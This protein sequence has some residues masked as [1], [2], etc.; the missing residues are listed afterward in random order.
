M[1]SIE[2]ICKNCSIKFNKNVYY[3]RQSL[4]RGYTN[5]FCSVK[6]SS[7]F[8]GVILKEKGK[9]LKINC[10]SSYLNNQ[11]KCPQCYKLISYKKRHNEYCSKKCSAIYTQKDKGHCK[12]SSED[13]E[14]I[15]LRV[16]D[17]HN[18]N[19]KIK[20][21]KIKKLKI[22]KNCN[23]EIKE[24]YKQ[25]CNCCSEKYYKFYRP[26]CEFNFILENYP[27]KF[28]LSLIKKY[29]KYSPKNKGNNLNG[30]SRDHLYSVKDGFK[31]KVSP[32]IIRHPS[33]CRLVKHKENQVK[34]NKSSISLDELKKRISE[35]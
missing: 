28:D 3:Y 4:K 22:C 7:S 6:C 31:N 17:Y 2:L 14:K 9:Q 11:K 34:Y 12:W 27:D 21:L 19:P 20:K 35:W 5:F 23:N 29:G 16:K 8:A 26:L 13:R 24:K 1:N 30:I 25:I 10:E 33:N 18:K 15:S 32:D